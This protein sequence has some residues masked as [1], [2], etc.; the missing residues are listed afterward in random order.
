MAKW[1]P[2]NGFT[3][4]VQHMD[5]RPGGSWHMSFTALASGQ[6]HGFGGRY[7][8]AEPGS[9]LRYTATFDDAQLGGEMQTTVTLRAVSC[10]VE[11]HVVQEGIPE[12]I[13]L[14]GCHLGWQESL[15]LL[16]LLVEAEIPG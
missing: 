11:L 1:L 6:T 8:E 12:P 16:T 10:G 9:R 4:E 5:A 3:G 2:P 14:E 7:L 15:A 13:P